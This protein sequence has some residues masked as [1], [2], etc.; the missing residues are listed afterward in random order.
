MQILKKVLIVIYYF[1]VLY[2]PNFFRELF[3]LKDRDKSIAVKSYLNF[4]WGKWKYQ[5][6]GD[7]MNVFLC[8]L[9]FGKT[10]INY[11]TSI[12]SWQSKKLKESKKAPIHSVPSRGFGGLTY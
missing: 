11:A 12:L 7:D 8:E 5:N 4:K 10:L 2:L 6:W 1:L 9:W 3:L